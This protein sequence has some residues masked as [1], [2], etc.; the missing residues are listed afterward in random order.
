MGTA[1]TNAV[2]L[3][4]DCTLTLD[5]NQVLG[6]N[7]VSIS[8]ESDAIDVSTRDDNGY[9]KE[10][11]GK[12]TVTIDVE[13]KR[14]IPE[15]GSTDTQAPLYDAWKNTTPMG[16]S[17]SAGGGLL[18]VNGTFVVESLE[19]SQDLDDAVV[20]SASLKNYG[21]VTTTASSSGT[22]D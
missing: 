12:K 10:L 16:C 19:E 17:V 21:A 3:G 7:S 1:L 15:T 6:I 22:G 9:A 5:S 2:K 14:I 8:C 18:T 20:I 11:P 13:L 4:K